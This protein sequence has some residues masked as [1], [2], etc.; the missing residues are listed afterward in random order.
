MSIEYSQL[1]IPKLGTKTVQNAEEEKAIDREWYNNPGQ[2]PKPSAVVTILRGDVKPWSEEWKWFFGAVALVLGIIVA[3]KMKKKRKKKGVVDRCKLCGRRGELQRSHFLPAA[4]Y[5]MI[6]R[7]GGAEGNPMVVTREITVQTSRQFW[8]HL[9]CG[10][11]EGRFNMNGEGYALA[12]VHN[13]DRFPLLD[14][15][16]VAMPLQATRELA[17]YSGSDIGIDVDQL[18][19]FAMSIFWR[20]SVHRWT[21]ASGGQIWNPLGNYEEPVRR[22]LLGETPFPNEMV[23]VITVCTDFESQSSVLSPAI[24]RGDRIDGMGLIARGIQFRLYTGPDIPEALRRVCCVRSE[25]RIIL[26][27]DCRRISL[28]AFANLHAN[29]QP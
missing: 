4:L 24:V 9:L 19:Y 18:A 14:L 13:A 28:Q 15:L 25:R 11:C 5:G 10:E 29:R 16:N 27:G 26:V 7:Q 8:A 21:S 22:Y 17:L 3:A 2:F 12:R 1:S 23:L 20:A 6:L